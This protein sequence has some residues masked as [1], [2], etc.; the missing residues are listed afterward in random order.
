MLVQGH[1][2]VPDLGNG[3]Q[4]FHHGAQGVGVALDVPHQGGA[5][6]RGGDLLAGQQHGGRSGDGGEGGAQVV[7]HRPQNIAPDGL[8]VRLELNGRLLRVELGVELVEGLGVLLPPGGLDGLGLD[9]EHGDRIA[10]DAQGEGAE[11]EHEKVV[12]AQ[13]PHHRGG[14]AVKI[15]VGE[16][17]DAHDR[18]NKNQVGV[19]LSPGVPQKLPAD[20]ARGAQ[21]Q[22]RGQQIPGHPRQA[23]GQ[24]KIAVV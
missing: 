14:D 12:D 16:Q 11:G 8:P 20:D 10:G 7:G 5:A 17:G 22:H 2:P 6:L 21:K 13:R 19:V 9:A 1:D 4:V 3:E 23:P 24:V 18:Q 15:S